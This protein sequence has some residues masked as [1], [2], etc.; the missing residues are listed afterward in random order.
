MF[1]NQFNEKCKSLK[2]GIGGKK[3]MTKVKYNPAQ[4]EAIISDKKYVRVIA[5]AGAGKTQVNS[6]VIAHK[7]NEL[8]AKP[9]EILAITFSKNGATE[10]KQR[11]ER[12]A[13]H[14]LP[15][16]TATTFNALE[17]EITLENWEKFGF[18]H[19]PSVIDDVQDLPMCDILLRRHPILEW[20]GSSFK[21][22][23]MTSGFGTNGALRIVSDIMHHCSK[24]LMRKNFSAIT[25]QDMLDDEIIPPASKEL[26]PA[27]I[28]KIISFYPEYEEM[29]KG[30]DPEFNTPVITFDEQISFCMRVLEDDPNYL[31]DHYDFTY[32]I[33]DEAQDTSEDQIEFLNHIINMKKFKSLIVVGDDSQAIYESL[34]GTSPDYLINLQNFLYEWDKE[35]G[36]KTPIKIH[37]IVM[38]T[39]YRSVGSVIEMANRVIDKNTNKFDKQLVAFREFGEKPT[40]EGFYLKED[41]KPTKAQLK[42]KVPFTLQ[43]GQYDKMARDIKS[44]I[45][46][47]PTI[48]LNDIAVL[49]YS[50]NELLS[51]ADKLTE[52]GIPSKFGAPEKLIDNN[53]VQAVLKFAHL[54]FKDTDTFSDDT[55]VVANA[56]A[57]GNLIEED[58]DKLVE[59][60]T[61]VNE[62]VKAIRESHELKKRE[63]FIK[64]LRMI[65]HGDEAVLNFEEKFKDMDFEEIIKYCDDFEVFG[66]NMQYKR[67]QLGEGVMLITAHSSKGLEWKYVFGSITGFHKLGKKS[68]SRRKQE[69]LRRLLFVLITRARD[70]LKLY[71]L[72]AVS[73]N[74]K[75]SRVYNMFLKECFEALDQTFAPN[76]TK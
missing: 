68:I 76:F 27:I 38:D 2:R 61:E 70:I 44:L 64:M 40:V 55:L 3:K 4:Q 48:N 37:D 35:T 49:A 18:R 42:S 33:V 13:G 53:R 22:Y 50:K 57:D 54:V 52:L 59:K 8:G 65:A 73:G 62:Y 12:T 41:Q 45:D 11:A 63:L 17:N 60:L 39:N 56:L 69:E 66:D 74:A 19:R 34:M 26:T 5:G 47:D 71:G 32:I 29:K 28:E 14:V 75:D 21:N 10:I 20:T 1:F 30:N 24:L 46:S 9:E 72:Y 43:E 6:E 67:S 16:L 36:V 25:Y 7:L 31:D 23:T 15:G 58:V 51:V